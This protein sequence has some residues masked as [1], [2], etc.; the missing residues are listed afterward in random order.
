M[1]VLRR[2]GRGREETKPADPLARRR[3]LRWLRARARTIVIAVALVVVVVLSLY[4]VYFSSWLAAT[5]VD[6]TGAGLGEQGRVTRVARVPIGTPLARIDL[7]AIRARVENL[8]VVESARVSRSWPHTVTIDVTLRTPVAVVDRGSG[9][10]ELD[11]FGVV[12]GHRASAG[13][14]P[15]IHADATLGS[16]AL[17]GAGAVA[18]SLPH[19]L[20]RRVQYLEIKTAD[21][22]EL[23]LRNGQ[24][25]LWG[26]AAD[27]D[28]K[29][30]V[31][32]VLLRKKVSL[33]DVSVPGRPSTRP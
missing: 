27:S 6:V 29:A 21:D 31:A 4:A 3:R 10:Q 19:S 18:G 17:A 28:Q 7:G 22:I 8:A 5:K 12:F 25:V 13:N 2:P 9:L 32:Q 26:S 24:R 11:R 30:E 23:L 15:L 20:N 33:V 1:P 14:L 16:K